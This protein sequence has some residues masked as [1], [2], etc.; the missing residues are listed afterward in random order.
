MQIKERTALYCIYKIHC[1]IL[2]KVTHFLKYVTRMYLSGKLFS[3]KFPYVIIHVTRLSQSVTRIFILNGI[4]QT[5]MLILLSLHRLCK[6]YDSPFYKK[7]TISS[8]RSG[9]NLKN[10]IIA[11]SSVTN[12]SNY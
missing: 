6:F 1:Q 8:D 9:Y 2:I 10:Q 3:Q 5:S 12:F 11:N 4:L 7:F